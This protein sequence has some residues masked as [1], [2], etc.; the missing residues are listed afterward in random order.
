MNKIGVYVLKSLKNS[1]YY[2]GSSKNVDHRLIE[3]NA[4][5]VKSTKGLRPWQLIMFYPLLDIKE[6]RRLEYRIKRLKSRKII[7]KIIKSGCI[8]LR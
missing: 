3:H 8:S 1:S 5:L 4:G 2:V 6:A 7:E